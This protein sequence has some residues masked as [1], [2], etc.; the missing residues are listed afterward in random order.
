L[1]SA[2]DVQPDGMR[3]PRFDRRDAAR[4]WDAV[5][6]EQLRVVTVPGHHLS[7]LDPPHV[8]SLAGHL[9]QLLPQV[10]RAAA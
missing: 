3:D 2:R 6:G 10:V 9:N 7:V 5:C 4:G 8:D 1:F